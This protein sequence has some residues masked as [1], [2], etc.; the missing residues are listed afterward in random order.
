MEETRFGAQGT[1]MGHTRRAESEKP[2]PSGEVPRCSGVCWT[3]GIEV[4]TW[5]SWV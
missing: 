1:R 3:E 2:E 5:E 4:R